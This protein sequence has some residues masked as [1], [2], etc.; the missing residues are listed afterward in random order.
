MKKRH[1]QKL[2]VLA[3]MMVGLFNIP[4]VFI[5]NSNEGIWG[6]PK[7]YFY[8]FS[9]WLLSILISFFILKRHYE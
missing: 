3:I 8:I 7:L 9:I 2:V 1:E 5:F 6:I 4:F